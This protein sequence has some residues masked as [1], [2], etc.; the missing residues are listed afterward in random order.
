MTGTNLFINND[1]L[2][3]IRDNTSPTCITSRS[4]ESMGAELPEEDHMKRAISPLQLYASSA[5]GRGRTRDC[6]SLN[7]PTNGQVPTLS[8]PKY[9]LISRKSRRRSLSDDSMKEELRSL[10]S[11]TPRRMKRNKSFTQLKCNSHHNVEKCILLVVGEKK[12]YRK[13]LSELKLEHLQVEYADNGQDAF[14]KIFDYQRYAAVLSDQCLPELE[15]VSERS[16]SPII[17]VISTNESELSNQKY[18]ALRQVGKTVKPIELDYLRF[19]LSQKIDGII[20]WR[21]KRYFLYQR[22]Q[23]QSLI[24][25]SFQDGSTELLVGIPVTTQHES[26]MIGLCQSLAIDL[27]PF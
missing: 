6:N 23:F 19:L 17:L 16:E 18:K 10:D 14:Q 21:V 9:A 3:E 20:S 11:H 15:S 26:D 2:R 22:T 27:P 25:F 8:N 13:I 12:R 5:R 1:I 7:S 4:D 24:L